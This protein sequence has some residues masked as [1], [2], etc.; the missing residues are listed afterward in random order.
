MKM[1]IMSFM[2]S[3]ALAVAPLPSM[4][5]NSAG[6]SP[7]ITQPSGAS[8]SVTQD[9]AGA[10]PTSTQ[11]P[12]ALTPGKAAGIKQA[13]GFGFEDNK[14]LWVFGAGAALAVG[15]VELS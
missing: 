1:K 5:A 14:L 12:K 15:I 8:P 3:I 11:P 2:V 10:L 9:T 4:A 13:Q 6:V 7:T